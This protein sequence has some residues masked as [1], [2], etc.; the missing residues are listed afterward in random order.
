MAKNKR[1]KQKNISLKRSNSNNIDIEFENI[2][3]DISE[4]CG[5][6]KSY[7]KKYYYFPIGGILSKK[8]IYEKLL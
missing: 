5:L 1:K 2:K 7:N 6:G 8:I 4:I 3:I